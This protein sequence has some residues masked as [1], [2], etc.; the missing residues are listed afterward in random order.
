MTYTRHGHDVSYFQA[1]INFQAMKA[2]GAEFVIIRCGYN[3]TE[4]LRFDQ[5][6]LGVDGILP[7]NV[8]HFYDPNYPPLLQANSI[9]KSLEPYRARITRVWM[10]LEFDWLG[11]YQSPGN[12]LIYRNAINAAGYKTGIYT[13][14]TWWDPRVGT[15]A[16]EFGRDPF[17][18][19]Q[20]A[21]ALTLIPK[22]AR[23]VL[24]WQSGAPYYSAG[25]QSPR[26]DYD[27]WNDDYSFE[28]EWQAVT[29]PPTGEPPMAII[30]TAKS[31]THNI[32]IRDIHQVSGSKSLG[33][34]LMNTTVNVIEVWKC[35]ATVANVNNINDFW[36]LIV[37]AAG[38]TLGWIGL[39]H[40][41][42]VYG[43]YTP[44]PVVVPPPT[45]DSITMDITLRDVKV[46]GDVYSAVG[47]KANK[48]A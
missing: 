37:N 34:V 14:A 15:Y 11:S 43:V 41:G 19:A 6:M 42:V 28:N 7:H 39:I 35:P 22:G 40:L 36:A 20:Y 31:T 45:G 18:V 9:I 8:Y 29:P 48:T 4:D 30:G 10:D 25:Q 47:V 26:I 13:R 16:A 38:V 2:S 24:I 5:Y 44:A 46:A 1:G 17:W 21:S 33:S 3:V 12:W 32:T 23:D 27:L